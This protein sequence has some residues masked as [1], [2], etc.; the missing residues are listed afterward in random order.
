MSIE[1][2]VHTIQ[3]RAI[4]I[5]EQLA[6]QEDVHGVKF[7][8]AILADLQRPPA[9]MDVQRLRNHT[10]G[11]YRVFLEGKIEQ[12]P[13]RLT[14]LEKALWRLSEDL[15]ELA[16]ILEAERARKTS[17]TKRWFSLPPEAVQ[18]WVQ[19]L[20]ATLGRLREWEFR[21]SFAS[22]QR[23]QPEARPEWLKRLAEPYYL[24]RVIRVLEEPPLNPARLR[25]AAHML[26]DMSGPEGRGY[27]LGGWKRQS[28]EG[29]RFV[30]EVLALAD[31]LDALA[32][33]LEASGSRTD[34]SPLEGDGGKD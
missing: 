32:E 21:K 16:Y 15:G 9:E 34:G 6:I 28:E 3:R 10:L 20:R 7:L 24:D 1:D 23:S 2:F 31:E 13:P 14:P 27:A 11:I 5:R 17:E 4:A 12:T 22:H 33:T 26:R 18:A 19:R 30:H 8:D 25:G 29:R